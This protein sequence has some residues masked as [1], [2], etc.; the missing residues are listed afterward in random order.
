[1]QVTP[2][3]AAS[4]PATTVLVGAVA[5]AA[6]YLGREVFIPLALAA[7]LSF[8][9]APLANRLKRLGL[10]R[11]LPVLVVVVGA[12]GLVS[13]FSWLLADQ[14]LRLAADL[15]RYEYNLR[16][17]IHFFET[18]SARD[19]VLEQT[20]ELLDRVQKEID[21]VARDKEDAA[22]AAD[23][24]REI[25]QEPQPIPVEVHEPPVSPVSALAQVGELV[26]QPLATLG[27]MLLFVIFVLL[28]REDLRDRFIRLFGSEDVHRT[29]EAM[30]DAAER[31]GRYLLMQLLINTTYGGLFGLGLWLL[32]VPNAL[33]WGLLG[34]VLR[35]VPYVG[36]PISALFP[37]V[38]SLAVDSG[39]TLPLATAG[40]FLAIE[41]VCAYVMEPLLYGSSTGLSPAALLVA[42]A[43]WTILWGPVGLLLATPLTA[44]LV[45]V[46][47]HVPALQ[48]L[49]IIFGNREVLS[50]SVKLYQRLLEE[51]VEEA[52]EAA[53]EFFE[54][55]DLQ[56]TFDEMMLPALGL[57]DRDRLRGALARSRQRALAADLVGVAEEL[58]GDAG[59]PGE[60][61]AEPEIL[62][63]GSRL[64]FDEASARL[65]ALLLREQGQDAAI[66]PRP[67]VA[68][69]RIETLETGRV[70]LLCICALDTAGS[71]HARRLIRRLRRRFGPEVPVLVGMWRTSENGGE[72]PLAEAARVVHSLRA[73]A[74][75]AR[76][77][78]GGPAGRRGETAAREPSSSGE[79]VLPVPSPG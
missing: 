41:L 59:V 4:S 50:P 22:A 40:L 17:K 35:F 31:I 20:A 15:P 37:L 44:C 10:G 69:G 76:E 27:L 16:Q 14:A 51:D 2:T 63:I 24:L 43:F 79:S 7:L 11:A 45:V 58:A 52:E 64:G 54:E 39:W 56:R 55:H 70:R 25:T 26:A 18:G 49:E 48:F 62:C 75:A 38:L 13:A 73:A 42:T 9:L 3:P 21:E 6:L 1:M 71:A 68:A 32:G 36:A 29:T 8:A 33:L 77:L 53:D 30:N 46:G 65:L 23:V 57:A 78:L 28:Q 19:N 5:V 60:P 72:E 12:L 74:V 61:P 66:L 47:R 67:D 34:S